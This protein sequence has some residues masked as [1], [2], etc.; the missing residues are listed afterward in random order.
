MKCREQAIGILLFNPNMV[1]S[2]YVLVDVRSIAL[3]LLNITWY[4]TYKLKLQKKLTWASEVGLQSCLAQQCR[5]A[6]LVITWWCV[7]KLTSAS[8]SD[9]ANQ[10]DKIGQMLAKLVQIRAPIPFGDTLAIACTRAAGYGPS[11]IGPCNV[12]QQ[13]NATLALSCV[14]D[15]LKPLHSD[16]WHRTEMIF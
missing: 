1:C 6:G 7:C 13:T 12:H 4:I 16:Q 10:A 8:G 11:V 5:R 9:T 3:N 14:I 2:M 15:L